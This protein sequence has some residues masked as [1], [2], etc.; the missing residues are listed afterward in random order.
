M[1]GNVVAV[2]RA[3]AGRVSIIPSTNEFI[4]VDHYGIHWTNDGIAFI[5]QGGPRG[6]TNILGLAI[7][8][9]FRVRLPGKVRPCNHLIPVQAPQLNPLHIE[10]FRRVE[11]DALVRVMR[12][13]PKEVGSPAFTYF[14]APDQKLSLYT[15]LLSRMSSP[16]SPIRLPIWSTNMATIVEELRQTNVQPLVISDVQPRDTEA[17]KKLGS[18]AS[19]LPRRLV[20]VGQQHVAIPSEAERLTTGITDL[21]LAD[22]IALPWEGYGATIVRRYMRHEL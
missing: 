20:V 2:E 1:E 4:P 12:P 8:S 19:Q 5:E 11:N 3:G 9:P 17:L 13:I 15:L 7:K 6:G 22:L 18:I 16:I 14:V 21:E 10:A